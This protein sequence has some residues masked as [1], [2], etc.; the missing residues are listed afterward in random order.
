MNPAYKAPPSNCPYCGHRTN[1]LMREE[2]FHG[3]EEVIAFCNR[4]IPL[5][6]EKIRIYKERLEFLQT[7]NARNNE[8]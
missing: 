3:R 4:Q 7:S 8:V 6:E 1:G 2:A 5:L